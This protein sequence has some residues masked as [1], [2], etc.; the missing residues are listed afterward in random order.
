M[1]EPFTAENFSALMS[2]LVELEYGRQNHAKDILFD[3]V[4][5]F[6]SKIHETR[7]YGAVFGTVLDAWK[8]GQI[9]M[10]SRDQSIDT[11]LSQFR[12]RLPWECDVLSDN[13]PSN[14]VYPVFTSVSGNK[15]DRYIERTFRG[16]TNKIL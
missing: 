3:F 1:S 14:W 13:C 9:L 12:P 8:N 7:A 6:V 15:S 16:T 5:A 4:D 2:T 10:A 11:F